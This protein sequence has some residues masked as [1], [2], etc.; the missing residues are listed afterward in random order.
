MASSKTYSMKNVVV[1]LDG[2]LVQGFWDGD[3]AVQ[4][5]RAEDVGTGLVGADGSSIFSQSAN[6]SANITLRLQHTSPTHRLLMQKLL[7][8]Q[9]VGTLKGF[10][11]SINERV[12]GEGGVADDCYI[13]VAPSDQKG[14][15]ASAREWQLWTGSYSPNVPNIV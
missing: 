8:Q 10:P 11:I 15:A 5:E 7:R 9:Q 4:I 3:D 12:S 1:M 2:Q 6:E 13:R 14:V